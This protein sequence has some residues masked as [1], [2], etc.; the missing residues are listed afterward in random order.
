MKD[1]VVTVL[2]AIIGVAVLAVLVSNNARTMGV[3]GT[4]FNGLSNFLGT[5]TAPVTGNTPQ[6]INVVA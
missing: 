1:S 2:L 6:P 5:A 3:I 4:S